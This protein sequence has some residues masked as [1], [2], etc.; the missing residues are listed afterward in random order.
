MFELHLFMTD[1]ESKV[2]IKFEIRTEFKT[3]QETKTELISRLVLEN[4]IVQLQMAIDHDLAMKQVTVDSY[5]RERKLMRQTHTRPRNM[6]GNMFYVNP[7]LLFHAIKNKPVKENNERFIANMR[8]NR[9]ILANLLNAI[10]TKINVSAHQMIQFQDWAYYLSWKTSA[11]SIFNKFANLQPTLEAEMADIRRIRLEEQARA[12]V[13]RQ[14]EYKRQQDEYL[15]EKKIQDETNVCKGC[16]TEW[17]GIHVCH[18]F[19][20][21]ESTNKYEKNLCKCGHEKSVHFET[22]ADRAA[23]L[24]PMT[25]VSSACVIL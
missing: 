6:R 20:S 23:G 8:N 14:I 4:E 10:R 21:I 25:N 13:K 3:E 2:E 9:S 15:V 1:L 19:V 16:Q 22:A 5:E 12:E 24:H 11:I 7:D 18:K 17:Y